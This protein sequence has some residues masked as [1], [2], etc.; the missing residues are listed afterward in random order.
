MFRGINAIRYLITLIGLTACVCASAH[1]TLD[2]S[3]SRLSFVTVK[4]GD[5]GEVHHFK[6]LNGVL[7]DDGVLD[8]TIRLASVDTLIP[9]RDE[10]MQKFLFET[11]L[12]PTATFAANIDMSAVESVPVGSSQFVDITGTFTV[13]DTPTPLS[14]KVMMTRAAKKS[15]VVSTLQPAIVSARA[16]GL[17][18]GVEKLRELAGLPSISDAVP[19]TFVLTFSG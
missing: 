13:R 8:V 6:S 10:R 16:L 19:V 11:E 1:W 12:F 14:L 18:E 2:N 9:I 15:V 17:S 7:Q 4:A 3:T 5:I